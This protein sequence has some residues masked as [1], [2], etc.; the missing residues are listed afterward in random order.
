MYSMGQALRRKEIPAFALDST[1]TDYHLHD[2]KHEVPGIQR[3][4]TTGNVVMIDTRCPG[5]NQQ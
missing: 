4:H 1:M 2:L 3:H 5:N